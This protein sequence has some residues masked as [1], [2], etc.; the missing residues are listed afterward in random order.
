VV[1]HGATVTVSSVAP[2]ADTTTAVLG[3]AS[4]LMLVLGL[5]WRFGAKIVRRRERAWAGGGTFDARGNGLGVGYDNAASPGSSP[6]MS[7][8]DDSQR[9]KHWCNE[10]GQIVA[11]Y[12]L[13]QK[14]EHG[15]IGEW[16]AWHIAPYVSIWAIESLVTP[17]AIGWWVISGDL[18]TDYLSAAD[19]EPPQ[20]PRK[21]L[22]LIATRW[23][24][25]VD[26]WNQGREY[27]G[28]QIAGNVQNKTL[29]PLLKSRANLLAEWADD[30]GLWEDAQEE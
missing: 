18:P 19:V 20:H 29:A 25:A 23:L 12:L 28:F 9:E 24:A 13:S 10:Q 11:R 6:P 1:V 27:E 21:A 26:A 14:V 30:D 3:Q 5:V 8:E 15:R 2:A 22:R 4:F 17:G 16:P 7:E